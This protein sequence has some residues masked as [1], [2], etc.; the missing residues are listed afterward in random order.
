[1]TNA[2]PAVSA[3]WTEE[4]VL[5]YLAADQAIVNYV[6]T[7]KRLAN[8]D[9]PKVVKLVWLGLGQAFTAG[10]IAGASECTA[11]AESLAVKVAN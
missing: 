6:A 11:A 4:D 1:M 10:L 9:E 3:F 2:P 8:I 7:L 5:D